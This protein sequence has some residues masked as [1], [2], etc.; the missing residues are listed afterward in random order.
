M[1]KRVA[2]YARVSSRNQ[3][4]N[5]S[6]D[7]QLSKCHE[8]AER[9]GFEV[10]TQQKEVITGASRWGARTQFN[11]LLK[12]GDRRQIDAIV[13]DVKHRLGRDRALA[14]LLDRA[15]KHGLEVFFA[16]G[17]DVDSVSLGVSIIVCRIEREEIGR[18]SKEGKL[19]AAEQGKIVFNEA[20]YGY[21]ILRTC[22]QQMGKK[23]N[24]S[25]LNSRHL[26]L[27]ARSSSSSSARRCKVAW[28]ILRSRKSGECSGF[29]TFKYFTYQSKNNSR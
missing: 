22:D 15:E 2:L 3:E 8:F 17:S 6:L 9:Q 25:I 21:R 4:D 27:T 19:R 14:T 16:D 12:M 13:V 5:T 10:I 20:P 23:T 7:N 28:R 18:R 11:E 24:L 29:W 26:L 1:I